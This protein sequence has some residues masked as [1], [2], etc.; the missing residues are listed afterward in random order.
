MKTFKAFIKPF[1][2][3]QRSLKKNKLIFSL[4]PELGGEGLILISVVLETMTIFPQLT[5]VDKLFFL[6]NL[7]HGRSK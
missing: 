3:P 7:F 2:I 6:L 4:L 5:N 1:E